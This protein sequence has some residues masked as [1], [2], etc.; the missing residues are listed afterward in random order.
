MIVDT[1][2][3]LKSIRQIYGVTAVPDYARLRQLGDE[4]GHVAE[5]VALVENAVPPKCVD[6]IRR[7]GWTIGYSNHTLVTHVVKI[8]DAIY[9]W[10]GDDY[11]PLADAL[12]QFGRAVI[13]C[14]TKLGS[15]PTLRQASSETIA[16]PPQFIE[17]WPF[18]AAGGQSG[19][20]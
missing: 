9:I 5:A 19:A 20:W 12:Q 16:M 6:E 2:F 13:L 14:N 15:R 4:R 11:A 17:A 7:L 10:G 3:A 1:A 8:A 18:G